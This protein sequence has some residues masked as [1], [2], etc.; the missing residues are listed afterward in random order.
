MIYEY[1]GMK[2]NIHP[3]VFIAASADVIGQV[4]IGEQSSVWFQVVIR[5][6]V[7]FIEIGARTNIQDQSCLHV[8]R[9]IAPLIIG[10]EVTVGHSVI[11]HG[12]EIADRVLIGM[13]ST[14]MDGAKIPTHSIVGARSLVTEGK[15]FPEGHL[16]MGSPAKAVRPLTEEELL[17]LPK[18]S[19]NYVQDAMDY[20]SL[21]KAI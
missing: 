6:D 16:I 5:G 14:I 18:S 3:S 21:V 7:N 13:G 17:F 19:A 12:C 9:K 2:P 4:K 15:T 8:T 1:K 10:S 20:L 11:L